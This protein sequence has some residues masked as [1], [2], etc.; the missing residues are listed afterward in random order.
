MW[1]GLQIAHLY[2]TE[3]LRYMQLG[4]L[5]KHSSRRVDVG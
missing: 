4:Y 5:V 1:Y 2:W 3:P